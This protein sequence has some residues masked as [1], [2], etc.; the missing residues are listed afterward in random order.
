ME[1]IKNPYIGLKTGRLTVLNLEKTLYRKNGVK[2]IVHCVCE[3]GNI[4]SFNSGA[5]G[6][7]RSCGCLLREKIHNKSKTSLYQV[8]NNIKTRCFTKTYRQYPD[9]G[10]RGVTMC[11][12]FRTNFL[13]FEKTMGKKP[14]FRHSIDRKENDLNY[15]CGECEE[16]LANG[17]DKNVRW[18]LPIVQAGNKRN[19]LYYIYK[20]K[21]LCLAEIAR[22]SKIPQPVLYQRLIK[23]KWSLEEATTI[24]TKRKNQFI[25]KGNIG[26]NQ[27]SK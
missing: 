12:K 19:N 22:K 26:R 6:N 1:H 23:L 14:S 7:K 13:F 2:T 3:C 20:G 17:W 24:P 21:E 8:W 27:Y 11:N 16:C 4:I 25:H 18:A 9:Y 15:S 5:F 10:G